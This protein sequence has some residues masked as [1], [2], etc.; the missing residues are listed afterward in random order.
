[1]TVMICKKKERIVPRKARKSYKIIKSAGSRISMSNDKQLLLLLKKI[2]PK[3]CY[4]YN[5]YGV[6]LLARLASVCLDCR[7]SSFESATHSV[8]LGVCWKH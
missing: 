2:K 4:M 7:F 5:T 1:M 6:S 8:S 3:I